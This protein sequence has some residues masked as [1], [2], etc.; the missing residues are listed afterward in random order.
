MTRFIFLGGTVLIALNGASE[1]AASRLWTELKAKRDKL[2]S[3]HQEF[4]VTR[5]FKGASGNQSS[6]WQIIVDISQGQWREASI[7]GSGKRIRI[8]DGKELFSMDEGGDEFMRIKRRPKD[9]DPLPS[10]YLSNDA[11]W[12]KAQEVER[13]PCGLPGK[14]HDCAILEVRLKPWSRSNSP[15]NTTNMLNGSARMSIDTETGLILSLGIVEA[16]QGPRSAYE[17]DVSYRVT[18]LSYGAP[19][20]AS[21]F[22]LPSEGMREVKEF[23][24]WNATKIKKQLTGTVAPELTAVDMEGKEITLSAFKGKT[25]LLDFWTTWCP[26]C[27]ADA[28]AL[29]KLYRQYGGQNLMI[30][31]ISVSEERTIV[32][33]F[34][35]EHP[36]SFPIVLTTENEMPAAYQIGVFPTYIIVEPDGTVASAAEGDQGFSELR[37]L[38]RKAGLGID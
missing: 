17:S 32:D 30:I 9:P 14:D 7:S 11:D 35:K 29:D 21:L 34:L 13:R 18:R 38:L 24:R 15:N 26:P 6:K 33:K 37:K 2:P 28:P 36:H 8:F 12:S 3:L 19:P 22:K 27:R 23:S 16:I 1:T 25:V 31:G 5:T 10:P 4:E 20:E